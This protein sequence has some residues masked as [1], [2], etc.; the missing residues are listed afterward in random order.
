M[1]LF[2]CYEK[3]STGWALV[4]YHGDK[5]G[6]PVGAQ[7]PERTTFFEVPAEMISDGD[8]PIMGLIQKAF[9]APLPE[10][11]SDAS[12]KLNQEEEEEYPLPD[13]AARKAMPG[14][15]LAMQQLLTKDGRRS[16]NATVVGIYD[17]INGLDVYTVVTD[18][19]NWL[20]LTLA[21]INEL[22]WEGS[23]IMKEYPNPAIVAEIEAMAEMG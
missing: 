5:P 10:G 12:L 13:W 20:K 1:K 21:E 18:A 4:V 19:N 22:Y 8:T 3:G 16:G 7:A 6:K 2:A 14:V 23:Y 11:Y 9:P 17:Q 15:L